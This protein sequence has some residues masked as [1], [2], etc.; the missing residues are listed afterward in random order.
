MSSIFIFSLSFML[1]ATQRRETS[2]ERLDMITTSRYV[3]S[4]NI[5]NVFFGDIK[6][7]RKRISFIHKNENFFNKLYLI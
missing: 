1:A 3:I 5:T 4:I 2:D 7:N 6:T